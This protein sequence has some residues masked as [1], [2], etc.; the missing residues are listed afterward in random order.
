VETVSRAH[1]FG[2]VLAA[3]DVLTAEPGV[4]AT[5]IAAVGVSYG[6]YLAILLAAR[7][8]V[9]WLALQAPAIYK[10]QDFDRPKRELNLDGQLP[11]YRLRRLGPDD[12]GVLAT[13]ARF[14]GDV[15]I[16][17]AERDTVIPHPVIANYLRAFRRSTASVT[18]RVLRGADH[19]LSEDRWRRLAGMLL[20]QWLA[21]RIGLPAGEVMEAVGSPSSKTR[22]ALIAVGTRA[23]ARP[24][25][26]LTWRSRETPGPTKEPR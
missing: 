7:R 16:L 8:P 12:N 3:Y 18:H 14:T 13:A 17:E 9:R 19:A 2:D 5:R 20:A 15:L 22:A 25:S 1:N 10:D 6:G 23:D 11:Q 21:A 4:D 24:A 26:A